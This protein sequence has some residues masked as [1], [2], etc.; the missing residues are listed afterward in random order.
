[1]GFLSTFVTPAAGG[2]TLSQQEDYLSGDDTTTSTT[3]VSTSLSLTAATRTGG[4]V[5][6][7]AQLGSANVTVGEPT[8]Y[9]IFDD[10]VTMQGD[11][12]F[13]ASRASTP[14]NVGLTQYLALNGSVLNVRFRSRAG[15][16]S[17]M[18]G[19]SYNQSELI[20]WEIS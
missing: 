18:Q 11:Q 1:M 17:T 7:I 16:T 19:Q 10:G 20:L 2:A 13:V 12:E 14:S 8:G 15:T 9:V 3:Y 5:L 6:I 4:F